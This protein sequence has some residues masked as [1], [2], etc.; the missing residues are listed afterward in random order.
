MAAEGDLAVGWRDGPV[1]AAGGGATFGK[2][3]KT[4]WQR[5]GII[6]NRAGYNALGITDARRYSKEAIARM[7]ANIEKSNRAAKSQ[8]T[9]RMQRDAE[10]G[11]GLCVPLRS[12]RL[13]VHR[14]H[15][16]SRW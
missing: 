16:Q 11:E 1:F 3:G 7:N 2:D 4:V 14:L 6:G 9:Q 12:L 5:A 8:P 15:P 13:C 10:M